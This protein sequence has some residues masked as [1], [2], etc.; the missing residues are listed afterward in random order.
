MCRAEE[1]G[2]LQQMVM[3]TFLVPP[4]HLQQLPAGHACVAAVHG[5]PDLRALVIGEPT[6]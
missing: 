1:R 4:A 6:H 2:L 3:F 5:C